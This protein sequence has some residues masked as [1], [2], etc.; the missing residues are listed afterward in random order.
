MKTKVPRHILP[1]IVFSQF[2]GTSLWFAGNAVVPDLI[3]ELGLNETAIGYITNAVQTGF[4]IGTL[5][6]ALLNVADRISPVKVFL[7][8][9]LLG[10][11]FNALTIYGSGFGELMGARFLTGFFLAG[12]YPVGMKIASDWHEKGLGKA[13]GYLVG[14]LVVGTAF[15]HFLKFAGGDLPWRFV[16]ISTSLIS[17]TGGL[18]LFF[19]VPDGPFKG[20]A[21]VFKPSALFTLFRQKNFRSAAFGYFGH[22][23]ELYTFWA[24]VP[25]ML[26][27]YNG[28]SQASLSVPLW[29]FLIIAIGGVACAVGGHVSLSMG[30]KK[31]A[32]TSL[33]TSALCCLL[34]PYMFQTPAWLFISFLLL[35]GAVVVSDSPQFSTMVAGSA[36]RS[37]VATGLTIVNSMGFAITIVSIQLVSSI[38]I[39]SGSPKIFWLLFLGPLAGLFAL[40]KFKS[41]N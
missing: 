11:A 35:W 15:P 29:S 30:S 12:I 21:G 34:V 25:V 40:H 32:F 37:Y 4:I 36:D 8:C 13:L 3:L 5:V 10:A 39:L 27:Y 17:I 19:T 9:S 6:F 28:V 41:P 18:V 1:V 26:A 20:K 24:F 22:M 33:M 31:V 2:A 23:W 14:A 16:L 38:W 7:A